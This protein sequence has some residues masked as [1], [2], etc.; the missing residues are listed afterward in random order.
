MSNKRLTNFVQASFERFINNL[1]TLNK[2]LMN[3]A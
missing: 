3:V 2:L 1:Q